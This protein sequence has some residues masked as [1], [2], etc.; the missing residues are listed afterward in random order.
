MWIKLKFIKGVIRDEMSDDMTIWWCG[1]H[2]DHMAIWF[3][4]GLS[5]ITSVYI[6]PSSVIELLT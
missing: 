4:L 3:S 6:H 2:V 1:I 5:R